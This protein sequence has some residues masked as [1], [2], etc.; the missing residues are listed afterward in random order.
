MR[1]LIFRVR[2]TRTLAYDAFFSVFSVR[3]ICISS[4]RNQHL[5]RIKHARSAHFSIGKRMI[6]KC[7]SPFLR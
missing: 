5:L 6:Y 1:L 7:V 3:E 4:V 2:V